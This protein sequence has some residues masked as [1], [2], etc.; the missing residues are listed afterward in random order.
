MYIKAIKNLRGVTVKLL[1]TKFWVQP[2]KQKSLPRMEFLGN[3]VCARL[4]ATIMSAHEAEVLI[5]KATTWT[6]SQVA[7]GWIR[8]VQ[9]EYHTFF[10]N[11]M[12]QIHSLLHVDHWRYLRSTDDAADFISRGCDSKILVNKWLW[13]HGPQFIHHSN[14]LE[15][16]EI[17][18]DDCGKRCI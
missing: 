16:N 1:T 6:D 17:L 9:T 18:L 4:V 11:R 2:L 10:E 8:G 5:S 7:L 15:E 13:W 14:T 3:V 12:Q